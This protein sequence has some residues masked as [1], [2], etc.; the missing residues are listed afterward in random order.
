MISYTT[1][2]GGLRRAGG[3]QHVLDLLKVMPTKGVTPNNY[4]YRAAL[5]ACAQVKFGSVLLGLNTAWN[6]LHT[7]L[8]YSGLQCFCHILG[9]RSFWT[10]RVLKGLLCLPPGTYFGLLSW[11]DFDTINT[12]AHQVSSGFQTDALSLSAKFW[13]QENCYPFRTS[14]C[15]RGTYSTWELCAER[16]FALP[17]YSIACCMLPTGVIMMCAGP[18]WMSCTAYNYYGVCRGVAQNGRLLP[19]LVILCCSSLEC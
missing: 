18:S 14:R 16:A 3:C 4:T 8:V 5:L 7:L 11:V 9:T 6:A 17:A 19:N 1:V 12:T 10:V 13:S 15:Q 2:M